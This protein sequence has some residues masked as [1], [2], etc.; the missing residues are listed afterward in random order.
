VKDEDKSVFNELDD[1]VEVLEREGRKRRETDLSP[2]AQR[3]VR[4][5]VNQMLAAGRQHEHRTAPIWIGRRVMAVAAAVVLLLALTIYHAQQV[6]PADQQ[7]LQLAV[8]NETAIAHLLHELDH[9]L[10]AFGGKRRQRPEAS[11]LKQRANSLHRSM[12]LCSL[13]IERELARSGAAAH[14][15][16]DGS[17]DSDNRDFTDKQEG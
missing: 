6:Q 16:D 5:Q 11:T 8:Q 4:A 12:T 9:D 10:D 15:G 17:M 13:Q 3:A 2:D 14:P 7:A 1:V